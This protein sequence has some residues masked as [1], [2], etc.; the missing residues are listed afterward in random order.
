MATFTDEAAINFLSNEH[1]KA[2]LSRGNEL[3]DLLHSIFRKQLESDR[4]D[5]L[6]LILENF[7][8]LKRY[9]HKTEPKLHGMYLK[10]FHGRS[11]IDLELDDWGDDGPWIG[12][13]KWFHCAYMT[14]FS[15]CFAGD[16]EIE[17]FHYQFDVPSPIFIC[18]GLIYVDGVYYGDWDL[19]TISESA[20]ALALLTG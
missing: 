16:E 3:P 20:P 19:H 8:I 12:P 1:V 15:L 7:E 5:T 14:T 2:L 17:I 9:T 6:S 10:L 13:I 18:N 4:T 11:P